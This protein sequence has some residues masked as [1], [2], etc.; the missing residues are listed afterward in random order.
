MY[1]ITYPEADGYVGCLSVSERTTSPEP[2]HITEKEYGQIHITCFLKDQAH[3]P[4]ETWKEV[5]L[6]IERIMNEILG[7]EVFAFMKDPEASFSLTTTEII[8]NFNGKEVS[9][10]L[11]FINE[12][13]EFLDLFLNMQRSRTPS[14]TMFL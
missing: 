3:L 8:F 1:P 4:K 11:D 9:R 14:P 12:K 6:K 7:E 13:E 5:A 10:F 2:P